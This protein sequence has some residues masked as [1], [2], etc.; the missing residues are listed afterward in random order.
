[1]HN[2]YRANISH[3]TLLSELTTTTFLVPHGHSAP[4]KEIDK[5]ID[6]NFNIKNLKEELSDSNNIYHLIEYNG[7]LAGFSKIILNQKNE[8]LPKQNT[9]ILSRIYLLE[10]FYDLSLGKKLF[11]FNINLVKENNQIGIWL[12]VW[13]ENHRAISFYKKMG[14][15]K[16]GNYDFKISENHSNPN[17]ILYLEF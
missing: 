10:K 8:N 9:A 15:K 4:K 7:E 13:T 3:A 1:L 12:A 6:K 11:K 17:H 2:I 16:V 14:F 5:Y